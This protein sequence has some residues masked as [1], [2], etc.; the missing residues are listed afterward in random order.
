[1]RHSLSFRRASGWLAAAAFSLSI[2]AHAQP[3]D[4]AM[5]AALE[6]ARNHQWTQIDEAAI[7]GHV[8]EG[9]VEYHR[10]R[11]RLPQ[12]EPG[13]ILDFIERHQGSP[14][15]DWMRGQ[16]ISRYGA[17]GRYG[18]L[19][20]VADGVPSGTERQCHYYTALLGSDPQA[21]AEGGRELWH[22]GRSQPSAC[23]TL[24]DHLR[25]SGEISEFDIW[26]RMMLAWEQGETGLVSYLGR[27]LGSRWQEGRDAVE[28][29]QRSYADITRVPT[30]IGP[31]CRG[32]GPLFAAAM[33]GF[34]RADTEAAMEAWRKIASH[35]PIEE[36]HRHAIEEDLAF[37]SLV[38]GIEHNLGWVDD[39]LP[40]IGT[41]R[42]LE[43]RIRHALAQRDWADALDWLERLP[44]DSREDSRWQYWKARAHEQ[45][46]DAERAEVAYARAAR[47]RDFF[48]FAAAD[49]I[50]RPYSL[51]LERSTFNADFRDQVDQW[52]TVQR[53]EA[54]LRIG[55]EGLAN[56]EWLH[57]AANATP[58]EVR[59]LADYAARRG[60]HARLVQTT[61]AAQLWDALDWR[62]PEAYRE[63]FLHW[64]QQTGVDP[65]LLM[66]I[67][68][69]ESAYN[70][71]A[72]SPAG[73]RGL[74][75][76]M[77]GTASLL[78]RQLGI[79]DPGPYGVLDPE[80]NIR[81]GSTY[82]RDMT[83][84]YR[85]NRLAAAAAYNAGPGRVDRWLRDAP[86]EF[87]L[88][89]ESIPFRE[90]RDYVQAVLSYRVIF[91]SLA[92]G[93]S[94]E[95]VSMLTRAEK[96][97]RYDASMLARN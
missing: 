10:L 74:M 19:L 75:Q 48:G 4:S 53:T 34:T 83:D 13:Q 84:R 62:F 72:L 67:A 80:L 15:A 6:A 50:G 17:A 7:R 35:L 44:D 47:E 64:G 73:A 66:G 32:S 42:V 45:L 85:G 46:G 16:A 36:T 51:N 76:L 26:E 23:D 20:A 30:C 69:R 60:W 68:R 71:E 81:L 79:S 54:L 96:T 88:F 5:R 89:V 2:T 52:P 1:M 37:Y 65:Y 57:A 77:P 58:R 24:F 29:L 9:Y 41:T 70:P 33:H 61:I 39:A 86:E 97:V 12:A 28:R 87:D 8:L 38:R 55:E 18:S 95:G 21:A 90:T 40:R 94:S 56:S 25:D 59:A 92:N 43:L 27:Q 3:S 93:G 49:R 78:S 31:E 82:I 63:H 11:S 14:V 22:V 91:E